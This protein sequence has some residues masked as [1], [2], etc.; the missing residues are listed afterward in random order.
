MVKASF[1]QLRQL[2]K[3]KPVLQK[4]LFETVI[5][6]FVTTRLDYCNALY[7]GATQAS[8]ARLQ[9][10][11]NAAARLLTN[12][13]KYDHITPILAS[14]HWLPVHFRIHF[15]VILFVFKALNGLAPLYLAELIQPYTPNRS[16]RSAD[17]QLLAVP[18][19]RLKGR[20]ERAF[21]VAAPKLWNAL[22]LHVRQAPSL[23]LF[24]TGAKTHLFSLAFGNQGER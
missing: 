6:A 4:K 7:M 3:V 19:A 20:G 23:S 21:A 5:H 17:Q 12:S 15:K 14:L 11:Q 2:A 16:L 13:R 8:I 9:L 1:F 10:V 18:R 22:P 24:K